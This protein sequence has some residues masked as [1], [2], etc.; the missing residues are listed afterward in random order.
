MAVVF[1][2]EKH[3][4]YRHGVFGIYEDEQS[5]RAAADAVAANE[6]DDYHE[7]IVYQCPVGCAFNPEELW[8]LYSVHRVDRPKEGE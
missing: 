7:F 4:V 5:A 6:P 1:Y 2:V 8:P 3:G